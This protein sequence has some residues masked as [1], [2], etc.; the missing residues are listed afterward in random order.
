MT[1]IT[2][3]DI[4]GFS[5]QYLKFKEDVKRISSQDLLVQVLAKSC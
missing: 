4:H 1:Q 2:E 5:P 3:S